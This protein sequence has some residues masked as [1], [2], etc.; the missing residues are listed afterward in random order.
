MDCPDLRLNYLAVEVRKGFSLTP[1]GTPGP[2]E[3][4]EEGTS[5]PEV[6]IEADKQNSIDTSESSKKNEKGGL[7][8]RIMGKV[9]G[10]QDKDGQERGKKRKRGKSIGEGGRPKRAN[11]K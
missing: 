3:I 7:F 5:D 10:R 11:R 8:G 4:D 2:E 1:Q 9:K 6:E